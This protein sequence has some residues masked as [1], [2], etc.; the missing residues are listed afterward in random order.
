MNTKLFFSE[1]NEFLRYPILTMS[2]SD[3]HY[4]RVLGIWEFT[5]RCHRRNYFYKT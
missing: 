3:T 1:D 2:L 5:L 4:E